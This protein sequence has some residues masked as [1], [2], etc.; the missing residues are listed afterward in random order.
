[1]SLRTLLAPLF[2]IASVSVAAGQPTGDT[3]SANWIMPGCLGTSNDFRKG[4]CFGEV[5]GLLAVGELLPSEQ[6][7]CPPARATHTQSVQVVVAYIQQNPARMHEL[8]VDL[9]IEALRRAWPC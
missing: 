7:F 3:N 6:R 9:A 1:M 2:L 4:V 5:G 8:F